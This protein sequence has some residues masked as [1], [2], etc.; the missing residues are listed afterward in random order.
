[1]DTLRISTKP[2]LS[3]RSFWPAAGVVLGLPMPDAMMPAFTK[4]GTEAAAPRRFFAICNNLGVLPDK[5]F[6]AAGDTG[7]GYSLSPYLEPIC[8]HRD[9]FT[10]FSGA[11]HPGIDYD[12]HTDIICF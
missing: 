10:V 5:F 6:P 2:S 8:A 11:S 12:E 9:H 1:M 4:A 7:R 3:R